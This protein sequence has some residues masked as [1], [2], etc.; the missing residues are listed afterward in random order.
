MDVKKLI[1]QFQ[2][3]LAPK[4]DT[5]EQALYLYIFR[6]SRLVGLGEVVIGFKSAR[7]KLAWGIGKKGSAMSEHQC[8]EK[9]R[10][11]QSKGCVKILDSTRSGTRL[12]LNL[13]HEIDGI[14]RLP[15]AEAEPVDFETLDFFSDASGRLAILERDG[16]KCFYCRKALDTTN[17]VIEHVE[18]RPEGNNTYRNLA[19]ACRSCNNRK[20][21]TPAEEFLRSCYRTGLLSAEELEDRLASLHLLK[22]GKLIP[23]L[24]S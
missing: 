11:L 21:D 10:S 1:E 19:A 14:V 23:R 16:K 3:F 18:S 9:L 4:L 22:D 6:H 20:G 12:H 13:P 2:D 24:Q 17:Y 15:L 8:Y 5:Y 7:M